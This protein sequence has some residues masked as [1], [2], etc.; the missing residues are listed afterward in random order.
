MSL[1]SRLVS[2]RKSAKD[3][4][5]KVRK[6]WWMTTLEI[7]QFG[8]HYRM[9]NTHNEHWL[10]RLGGRLHLMVCK[11]TYIEDLPPYRSKIERL[12]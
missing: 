5:S 2:L 12:E 10:G 4:D 6:L 3:A 9:S 1:L 11:K 7:F 8:S